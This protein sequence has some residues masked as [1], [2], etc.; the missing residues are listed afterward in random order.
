MKIAVR[1]TPQASRNEITGF[2]DGLL[3]VRIAAPPVGGKAN[4]QLCRFLGDVFDLPPSSIVVISGFSSKR[5]TLDIPLT[6]Q[7]IIKLLS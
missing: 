6:L 3:R 5:K 2:L 1:I 7:Q 4:Q